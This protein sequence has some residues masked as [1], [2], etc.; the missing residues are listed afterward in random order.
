MFCIF[1][2]SRKAVSKLIDK[3]ILNNNSEISKEL[4]GIQSQT[5]KQVISDKYTDDYFKVM[6]IRKCSHELSTPELAGELL[7]LM[8]KK[9]Y[10]LT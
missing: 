5:E 9:L 8:K 3:K 10:S 2:R 7:I 6:P 4:K 1:G